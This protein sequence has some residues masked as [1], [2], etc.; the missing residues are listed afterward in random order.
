MKNILWFEELSRNSLA[1]AGGKG[2]NLGEMTQ[3]GFPVPPGFVVTSN[4]YFKHLDKNNLRSAIDNLLSN[5]D[6]EVSDK[7]N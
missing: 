6:V 7:L 2:A 5:L 4:S 1:E 3:A